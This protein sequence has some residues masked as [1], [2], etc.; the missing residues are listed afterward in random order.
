MNQEIKSIGLP[1]K[2]CQD[3][4]TLRIPNFTGAAF[5]SS[6]LWDSSRVHHDT[7]IDTRTK[8]P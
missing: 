5:A 7:A 1:R 4:P 3:S 6:K 8:Y 2:L